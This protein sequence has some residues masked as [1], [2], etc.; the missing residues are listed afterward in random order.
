MKELAVNSFI[1]KLASNEPTPGGGAAAGVS[2]GLGIGA[3]L[4]AMN[5]STNKKMSDEDKAFLLAK[6]DQYQKSKD[7]LIELIDRDASDFEPLSN[8]YSMPKSTDEEKRTR[9]DAIQEGLK[10][11]SRPP[12]ELLEEVESIVEDLDAIVPLIKKIII[13]DL[14]VGVQMLRS[15][16]HSSSLNLSINAGQLKDEALHDEYMEMATTKVNHLSDR[17]DQVYQTVQSI[18]KK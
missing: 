12:L 15:A 18:L 1:D 7:H 9:K 4:M 5:F 17:L 8:A 10:I 6:I 2:A 16:V 11:A 13:S 14:G 3:I